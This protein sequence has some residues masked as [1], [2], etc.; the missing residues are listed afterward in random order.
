MGKKHFSDTQSYPS[1]KQVN[2]QKHC[3][4]GTYHNNTIIG[5]ITYFRKL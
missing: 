5:N 2:F 3:F 1:I 4:N